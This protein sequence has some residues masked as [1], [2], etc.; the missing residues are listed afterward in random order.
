VNVTG[1]FT[2]TLQVAWMG[3]GGPIDITVHCYV[4]TIWIDSADPRNFGTVA[5]GSSGSQVNINLF[6]DSGAS[7]NITAYTTTGADCPDF[8]GS[9]PGTPTTIPSGMMTTVSFTFTPTFPGTHNCNFNPNDNS[10]NTDN[11]ID[12]TGLGQGGQLDVSPASRDFMTQQVGTTSSVQTFTVTNNG[13]A[14]LMITDVSI[15][16]SDDEE[17]WIVEDLN[18]T[19][20]MGASD[21][22]DVQFSPNSMAESPT[23]LG[24]QDATITITSDDGLDATETVTVTGTGVAALLD[25]SE[26]PAEPDFADAAWTSPAGSGTTRTVT[27]TNN[28]TLT[29][30]VTGSSFVSGNGIFA[31]TAMGPPFMLTGGQ[32]RNMTVRCL[33][34]SPAM[35]GNQSATL[36]LTSNADDGAT[37]G[38]TLNC[39]GVRPNIQVS[40]TADMDFGFV[41]WENPPIAGVQRTRTVTNATDPD[42]SLLTL[43]ATSVTVPGSPAGFAAVT[44]ADRFIDPGEAAQNFGATWTPTGDG[45]IPAS[46]FIHL[47]SNDPQADDIAIQVTGTAVSGEATITTPTTL[48][49]GNVVVNTTSGGL[50]VTIRND[51]ATNHA[52]AFLTIESVTTTTSPTAPGRW[53][54][55]S[56]SR[57]PRPRPGTSP[58]TRRTP[59]RRPRTARWPA[60]PSSASPPTTR[61]AA[62]ARSTSVSIAPPSPPRWS[63]LRPRSTTATSA[64]ASSTTRR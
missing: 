6:N 33:P 28:G 38:V 52:N 19:L 1:D 54:R 34:S 50:A 21:T 29:L 62:R 51:A 32:S 24:A 9:F 61:T 53:P 46:T 20:G 56:S 41:R 45:A 5:L 35:I 58:A 42:G 3:G 18:V 57:R 15:A 49:F 7:V 37:Q 60:A 2:R 63:S 11:D 13:N 27:V 59:A 16:V 31:I 48:N 55:R 43:D 36:N 64:C 26:E 23:G 25:F 10:G 44:P 8:G 47:L 30:N 4:P 14:A 12:L 17:D 22:F 40:S 39:Q